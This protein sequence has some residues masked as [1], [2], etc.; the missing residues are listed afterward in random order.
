MEILFKWLPS[1]KKLYHSVLYTLT[2]ASNLTLAPRQQ[3]EHMMR[4][5]EEALDTARSLQVDY[6][7]VSWKSWR[8]DHNHV[9]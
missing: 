8:K 3:I 1:A 7:W 9:D 6:I 2:T 4:L 5:K